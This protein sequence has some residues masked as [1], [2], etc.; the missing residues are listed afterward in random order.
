MQK[1]AA[2]FLMLLIAAPV[3]AQDRPAAIDDEKVRWALVAEQI[4]ASLEST[5]ESIK[6]Q[7]LKN[8]I[9]LATLYR[10]KVKSKHHFRHLC[11]VYEQSDS[12]DHRKLALA[13]LEAIG[14]YRALDYVLRNATSAEI[15]EGRQ[16]VASVLSDYYI[17]HTDPA[18]S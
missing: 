2:F 3:L 1:L 12:A 13:A 10:D 9:V 4:H 15:E 7:T 14:G 6:T 16:I 18:S 8:V 17:S 11:R 5:N